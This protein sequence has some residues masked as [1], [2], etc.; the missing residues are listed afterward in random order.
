[1]TAAEREKEIVALTE[2]MKDAAK[3]LEF[4]LAAKYRDKINE[5]KSYKA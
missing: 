5:L 1:M 4:E 3:H 2:K